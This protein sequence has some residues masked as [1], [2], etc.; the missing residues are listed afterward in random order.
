M[1][2]NNYNNSDYRYKNIID[3]LKTHRQ[4]LRDLNKKKYKDETF[5]ISLIL[6]TLQLGN[7]LDQT[8]IDYIEQIKLAYNE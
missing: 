8:Q 6:K 1:I 7:E 3:M 5:N 2:N 4:W